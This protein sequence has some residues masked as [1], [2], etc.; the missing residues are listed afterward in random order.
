MAQNSENSPL[1]NKNL[2]FKLRFLSD[3]HHKNP[4]IF[5]LQSYKSTISSTSFW[6]GSLKFLLKN[7]FYKKNL[8]KNLV[9]TFRPWRLL[10]SWHILVDSERYWGL[11]PGPKAVTADRAC[12]WHHSS[13]PL[14]PLQQSKDSLFSCVFQ[15]GLAGLTRGLYTVRTRGRQLPPWLDRWLEIWSLILASDV[16]R[17]GKVINLSGH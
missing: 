17:A 13:H 8:T 7:N 10:I 14:P 9:L 3:Q 2:V 15:M 11:M 12:H 1:E 4:K 16:K 6:A 5:S